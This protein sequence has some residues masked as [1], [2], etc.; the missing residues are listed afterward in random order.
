M[1]RT[2]WLIST[3]LSILIKYPPQKKLID[4]GVSWSKVKV[5]LINLHFSFPDDES[6][7]NQPILIKPRILTEYPLQKNPIDFG[8]SRSRSNVKVILG[9]FALL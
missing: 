6:N 8:L 1:I 2:K 5:I 7:T 3:K 9:L 4:F